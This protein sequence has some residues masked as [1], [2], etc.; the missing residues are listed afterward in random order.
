MVSGASLALELSSVDTGSAVSSRLA[1]NGASEGAGGSQD[2]LASSIHVLGH[3]FVMLSHG[4]GDSED[5]IELDVSLVGDVLGLFSVSG[6]FLEGFDQHTSGVGQ[7]FD[8]AL[9]VKDCDLNMDFDSLPLGGGLLDV[10]SDFLGWHTDRSALGCEGSST[11]DFSANHFHVEV[12]SFFWF[13]AF[14]WHVFLY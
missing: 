8:R 11:G 1:I 10:F 5:I 12:L 7:N 14:R 2:L 13:T 3:R 6:S 4:L 9:S